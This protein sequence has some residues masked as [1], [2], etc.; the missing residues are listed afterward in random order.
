VRQE[1]DGRLVDLY[2]G[3][4]PVIFASI[5]CINEN[6]I[7]RL[8][9]LIDTGSCMTVVPAFRA[10]QFGH[11]NNHPDV[12]PFSMAGLGGTVTGYWHSFRFGLFCGF[13]NPPVWESAHQKLCFANEFSN[14]GLL[15][16]DVIK[17]WKEFRLIP[18]QHGGRI[19]LTP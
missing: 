11:D 8:K 16:M 9:F 4:L 13:T 15:G 5:R 17:Q 10:M 1:P 12:E 2:E 19:S 18:T 3:N 14:Y 7:F 6:R